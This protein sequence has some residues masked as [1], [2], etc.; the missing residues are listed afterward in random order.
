[1]PQV[2]RIIKLGLQDKATRLMLDGKT[3]TDIAK[4]LEVPRKS[5]YAFKRKMGIGNESGQTSVLKATIRLE[6]SQEN[7][8]SE[9]AKQLKQY[10][11]N[12]DRAMHEDEKAAILWSRNRIDLLKE[13]FRITGLYAEKVAPP[14]PNGLAPSDVAHLVIEALASESDEVKERVV[15]RLTSLVG[16]QNATK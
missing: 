8:L 15:A 6:I 9:L 2:N 4:E 14:I 11:D 13:M 5:V 10:S 16:G 7:A 12:Y 1:M 3:D